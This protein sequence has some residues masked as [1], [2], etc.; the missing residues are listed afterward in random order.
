MSKLGPARKPFGIMPFDMEIFPITT[1][2]RNTCT[3]ILI[4][5]FSRAVFVSI[6][7]TQRSEDII[8]LIDSTGETDPIKPSN[9]IQRN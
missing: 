9:D 1:H 3:Y 7:E 8:K 6:S 4:D 5:H 2:Q